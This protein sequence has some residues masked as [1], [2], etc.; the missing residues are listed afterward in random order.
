[1]LVSEVSYV[2]PFGVH[3][4]LLR[5]GSFGFNF[6]KGMFSQDDHPMPGSSLEFA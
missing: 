2:N 3:Q 5:G 6:T 4:G 1:M